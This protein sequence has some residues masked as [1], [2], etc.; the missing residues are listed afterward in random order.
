M[1]LKTS[2]EREMMVNTNWVR[3]H[4]ADS[5]LNHGQ[6]AQVEKTFLPEVDTAT[7]PYRIGVWRVMARAANTENERNAYVARLRKV[8]NDPSATDR[9]SATETLCKLNVASPVDNEAIEQ[10]LLTADDAAAAFARWY[11][12]LS[13][14]PAERPANETK[15]ANLIDSNDWVARLRTAYSLGRLKDASPASLKKLRN[16]FEAEPAASSARLYMITALLLHGQ[17]HPDLVPNLEKQL[18]AY[19]D[20]GNPGE[21]LE[22]GNALG[23][24]GKKDDLKILN[25]MLTSPEADARIG[26]ANGALYL[27]K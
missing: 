17:H 6:T 23:L 25:S 5:L 24:R 10:W 15:L 18:M 20:H 7:P 21:Q 22:A 13:S 19:I 2:L 3:V 9:I 26:G 1:K 11:L 14:T 27:L 16:R 8:V 4:A 12:V